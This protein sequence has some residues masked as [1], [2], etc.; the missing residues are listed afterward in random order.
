MPWE[1]YRNTSWT[2]RDGIRK[3]KALTELTKALTE[4]N[5]AREAKN[6]KKG[7]YRYIGQ[8][9]K[10]RESVPPPI[11]EKGEL[12]TT[13]MEKAEVLNN[14]FASVFAASQASHVSQDPKP[15]GEGWGGSKV[16]PT[17]SK[18]QVPDNLMKLNRYKSACTSTLDIQVHACPMTRIPRF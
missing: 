12:I 17:I 4:L 8:K 3:A 15:V 10:A 18:E 9:R 6:N 14:F 1:E 16:L 7:F 11:N 2:R 5:L 13:N